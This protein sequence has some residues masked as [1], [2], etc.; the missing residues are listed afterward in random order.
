MKKEDKRSLIIYTVITFVFTWIFWITALYMGYKDIPFLRYLNWDF[1]SSSQV[2]RHLI[3]RIGVYGPLVG[4]LIVTY[5][6]SGGQGLRS[7]IKRIFKVKIKM[8]WYLYLFLIPIIINF[9]VVLIGLIIGININ[10]FFK[11]SIPINYIL[12]FF[13]YEV[14][15]SGLE[16]P[17]WRGFALEKLQNSFT[18]EKTSWILGLIWAVWH[19]PYVIS[20]YITSGFMPMVLSLAGFSMAIIGQT[21]IMIWFYNNTNSIFVA[22]LLH[23]WLNTSTTFVLGD[24]TI[25]NPIMGIIPALVTW[26][27]VVVLLKVYGGETLTKESVK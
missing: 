24:I 16:E 8:K 3:F 4:S 26:A 21:F 5:L 20:L 25:N 27:I 2:T 12:V 22:I 23:A 15:T 19:Y 13:I 11:S 1:K 17:G 18:A 14:L 6:Y 9:V 10:S 7:F